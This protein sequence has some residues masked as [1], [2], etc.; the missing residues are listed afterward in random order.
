MKL[1]KSDDGL[2]AEIFRDAVGR[3]YI[4][5]HFNLLPLNGEDVQCADC[6]YTVKDHMAHFGIKNS[7]KQIVYVTTGDPQIVVCEQCVTLA[8]QS[9]KETGR[10]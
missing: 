8:A 1:N 7:Y 9:A 6:G 4:K 3:A 5:S 10:E 2:K